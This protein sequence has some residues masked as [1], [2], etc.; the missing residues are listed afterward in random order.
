MSRSG[1]TFGQLDPNFPADPKFRKL[2]RLLDADGFLHAVGTWTIILAG[3]VRYGTNEIDC[4]AEAGSGASLEA[5]RSCGLLDGSGIPSKSWEK[6]R[7]KPRP[8][9]PSDGVPRTTRTPAERRQDKTRQEKTIEDDDPPWLT[10]WLS[11]KMRMPTVRQRDVIESYVR[12][13]DVTGPERAARVILGKPDDP[14]GALLEDLRT[15][16]ESRKTDA[17]E[18]EREALARRKVERKGFRK[19]SVEYDLAQMLYA[20]GEK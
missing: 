2:A 11:L 17:E 3:C 9:Y 15:F 19:G 14:I 12:V 8:K 5:L 13:F 18:A 16:R 6:W 1:F 10:A 20:K 7:P 4:E